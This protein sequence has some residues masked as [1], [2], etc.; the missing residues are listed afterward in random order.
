DFDGVL[1]EVASQWSGVLDAVQ[2]HTPDRA[3]D[4]MLNDWLLYQ[5]T[6][7]RLWART[8]GYQASGAYGFRDQLQD[9]MA[10]CVSRPDLARGHLLRAAGRQFA[11]GDVQHW[12]LPPKGQGIRTRISDDRIWLA[13]VAS[14]YLTVTGDAAVLDEPVAFLTGESIAEGATDAFFQPGQG[15]TASLYEHCALALDSSLVLGAHDLP[16][17]GTGDWNDGYNNV[18]AQG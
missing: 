2:V 11:A 8:A 9:V 13:Y 12:W 14:H 5:V 1:D 4:I 17:I 6:S 10:L 7:C 18:G 16:L 3:L 15:D